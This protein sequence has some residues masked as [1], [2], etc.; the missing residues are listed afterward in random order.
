MVAVKRRRVEAAVGRD[1][2]AILAEFHHV[3]SHDALPD[4]IGGPN[5]TSLSRLRANRE[6]GGHFWQ[7]SGTFGSFRVREK[8]L[9]LP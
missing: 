2:A 3:L 9:T 6:S 5:L 4:F 7:D 8:T 1:R